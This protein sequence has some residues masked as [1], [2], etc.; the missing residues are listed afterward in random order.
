MD[1]APKNPIDVS[2]FNK[3]TILTE[4][5]QLRQPYWNARFEYKGKVVRQGEL[6]TGKKYNFVLDLAGYDFSKLFKNYVSGSEAQRQLTKEISNSKKQLIIR[7]RPFRSGA[8]GESSPL[9]D[10]VVQIDPKR[11]SNAASRDGRFLRLVRLGRMGLTEFAD[12]VRAAWVIPSKP[13]HN[14]LREPINVWL[15]TTAEPGCAAV[16]F[17]VWDETG[18]IPLDHLVY[19]TIVGKPSVSTNHC[20]K[21]SDA[22][23]FQS[24]FT[25]LVSNSLQRSE[26]AQHS[27]D[28]GLHFFEFEIAPREIRSI[29]VFADGRNSGSVQV[30]SWKTDVPL[31]K[32]LDVEMPELIAEAQSDAINE[33]SNAYAHLAMRLRDRIFRD[34][35]YSEKYNA[36]RAWEILTQFAESELKIATR[37]V[38]KTGDTLYAPLGL[39]HAGGSKSPLKGKLSIVQ[40]LPQQRHL[41]NTS[42]IRDWSYMLPKPETHDSEWKYL[43]DANR[44]MPK[45]GWI[46]NI[47]GYVDDD[48]FRYLRYRAGLTADVEAKPEGLLAVTHQSK[49]VF[50]FDRKSRKFLSED[51]RRPYASGSAAI[52]ATCEAAG[53]DYE[54]RRALKRLST[55]G[56][57]LIIAAPFQVRV[58]Y[59]SELSKEIDSIIRDT[60]KNI[61]PL[62][63]RRIITLFEK[64]A[65]RLAENYK[66]PQYEDMNRQFTILGNP[67]IKLCHPLTNLPFLAEQ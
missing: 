15:V 4:G 39:L 3:D 17:S 28:G 1:R 54:N 27:T 6:E 45:S 8:F 43:K 36:E 5:V 62:L 34:V 16:G 31:S 67:N 65:S 13:T 38:D 30:F 41:G 57:D 59:G 63:D 19:R 47:F 40:A 10:I 64:A 51:I 2:K 29:V 42:C 7:L 32:F 50:W 61:N 23:V 11:F 58:K 56:V 33:K 18:T 52:L 53:T 48:L 60:N 66:I 21:D 24:G 37:L 25:T 35:S 46:R 49:G 55:Q 44:I 12:N 22:T 26:D 14:S 20:F 9:E